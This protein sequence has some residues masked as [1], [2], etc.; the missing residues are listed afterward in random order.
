MKKLPIT[1]DLFDWVIL[2]DL[3]KGNPKKYQDK[4]HKGTDVYDLLK[5][6]KGCAKQIFL[7]GRPTEEAHLDLVTKLSKYEKDGYTYIEFKPFV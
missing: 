4:E 6:R 7:D 2:T 1:L 3:I 5:L